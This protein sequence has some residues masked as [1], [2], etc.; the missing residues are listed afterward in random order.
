MA[1]RALKPDVK[2]PEMG[3]AQPGET[4]APPTTKLDDAAVAA[5][6]FQL[7]QERGS[8][9]GSPEQDWFRAEEE[10]KNPQST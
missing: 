3:K 6:A 5:R 2:R 4:Q 9:I 8:P 1:S 10:L 7:W